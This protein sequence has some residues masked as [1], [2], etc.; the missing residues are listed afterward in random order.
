MSELR[1]RLR[2][3]ADA[4]ARE[5]RTPPAAAL[6]R[7]GRR[8]RLRVAGAAA[9][10][11][12]LLLVAV[13]VGTDRL[14]APPPPLAPPS[15]TPSTSAPDVS[16]LP[17]PG[18]VESS[19]GRPPG[20]TGRQMV[21]DVATELARCRGGDPD[22]PKVLVGWGTEHDRTWLVLAKPPLPGE[23]WLCWANGLF[24]ANGAGSLGGEGGPGTPLTPIRATGSQNLRSGGHWW[25]Q[26]IGAVPKD[27]TRVRVLFHKGIAPLDLPAIQSGDRFPRNFFAG[28]YRQPEK[29]RHLTWYVAKVVAYDA[30]GHQ[31]AECDTDPGPGSSC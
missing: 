12:A 1:E 20:S 3:A 18:H 11:V 27:A 10:L 23:T 30:D 5:G 9:V 6:I 31:V 13:T 28:F 25:G 17:D 15:T 7:R 24:E 29:D 2:E 8:R 19:V 21:R 4:A 16:I 22:A 26:V 14:A